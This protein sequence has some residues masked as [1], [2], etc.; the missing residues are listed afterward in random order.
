M[1]ASLHENPVELMSRRRALPNGITIEQIAAALEAITTARVSVRGTVRVKGRDVPADGDGLVDFSRRIFSAD[2]TVGNNT[3]IELLTVGRDHFQ[4]LPASRQRATGML[5]L[6]SPAGDDESLDD[7]WDQMIAAMPHIAW[8]TDISAEM[9]SGEPVHRCSF[10]LKPR[11]GALLTRLSKAKHPSAA[12]L[13]AALRA[14]GR[15]RI[16]LDV[17]LADDHALRKVRQHSTAL[18]LALLT[19][20]TQTTAATFEFGDFGVNVDLAPP[21]AGQVLGY[22]ESPT[23]NT[24]SVGPAVPLGRTDAP[25]EQAAAVPRR[26]TRKPPRRASPRRTG[27]IAAGTVAVAGLAAVGILTLVNRPAAHLPAAGTPPPATSSATATRQASTPAATGKITATLASPA[28][29]T[30]VSSVAFGPD[31]T[32]AT[33]DGGGSTYLWHITDG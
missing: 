11:R 26:P 19:G 15:D 22:P 1:R 12:G 18:E 16:F 10:L 32:L 33:G 23:E 25:A 27:L 6:W 28:A 24:A 20:G 3:Q 17:W 2:L 8:C 5:W 14:N 7:T 13:Y 29:S 31:G 9:L 30:Y 21:P 4:R